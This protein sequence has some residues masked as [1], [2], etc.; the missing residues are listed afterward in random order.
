VIKVQRLRLAN[1]GC[2][3][4]TSELGKAAHAFVVEQL[5]KSPV[6]V[7]KTDKVDLHGRYVG[8]VLYAQREMDAAKVFASGRYLNQELLDAG[9]ATPQ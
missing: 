2:E 1:V 3:P 4:I 8:H 6:V 9:L 7:V 5:A